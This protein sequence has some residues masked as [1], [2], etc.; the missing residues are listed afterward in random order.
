MNHGRVSQVSCALC[1]LSIETTITGPL[2]NTNPIAAHQNCLLFSSGIYSQNSPEFDDLFGFSVEDVR[3]EV[4]RGAQLKCSECK[5]NGAT[6]G[7]EVKR[8]QKSYHYPCA[9]EGGA[10]IIEDSASET[11]QVYC[12]KHRKNNPTTSENSNEA[13]PSKLTCV[14]FTDKTRARVNS[15][16]SNS[17]SSQS[18]SKRR[19]RF[20]DE[21]K[22]MP[23]KRRISDCSSN[24]DENETTTESQLIAP[25]ESDL[26]ESANSIPEQQDAESQSL[27]CPVG[28]SKEATSV[29][30]VTTT[31]ST[32]DCVLVL[33]KTEDMRIKNDG[34]CRPSAPQ[35]SCAETT[36]SPDGSHPHSVSGSPPCTSAGISPDSPEA[37]CVPQSAMTHPSEPNID[38]VSFWKGCTAAG[39]TEAI[40]ADFMNEM[41]NISSRIQSH[42]ASQEGWN[43]TS[44]SMDA[45][46]EHDGYSSAEDPLNSEPED[47]NG[48]RLCVGKYTVMADYEKGG[49]D[50]SVKSGDMVQL[51]KEGDEGQW[52][53]RNPSTSKEGW[54]TAANLIT[55]IAKSK[56]CQSL[57][58]SEGSGSGNL[59]TSSSCSETYTNFSDIKP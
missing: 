30:V 8:C 17:S 49:E 43:K 33:H 51:V 20:N 45:S 9:V 6:V 59:S 44:L 28:S 5:K 41:N 13:G 23:K 12:P 53:V 29:E 1:S 11:Y 24:S 48:K 42:Q 56:S 2:S 46:E 16:D 34:G 25:L 7:C 38:S 39:C 18:R 21:L 50:L 14:F 35:Q 27:L 31:T 57:T 22:E 10:E 32:A 52:L 54:I 19:L 3:K 47:D 36:S 4:K 55:L 40:F 15:S 26:D 37:V 58:S